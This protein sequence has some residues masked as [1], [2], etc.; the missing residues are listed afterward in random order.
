LRIDN[1]GI[2]DLIEKWALG[3]QFDFL[4]ENANLF[5][6]TLYDNLVPYLPGGHID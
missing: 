6:C 4:V 2:K 1:S 3:N 5:A